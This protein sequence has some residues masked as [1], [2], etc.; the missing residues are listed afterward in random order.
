ML[1]QLLVLFDLI[2]VRELLALA[3]R[4]FVCLIFLFGFQV[5]R[6]DIVKLM[7][8]MA[9]VAVKIGILF[10]VQLPLEHLQ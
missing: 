3:V 10:S 8:L 9:T 4:E 1:P 2:Q 5:F 6:L 7:V